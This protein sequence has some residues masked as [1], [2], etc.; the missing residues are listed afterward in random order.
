MSETTGHHDECLRKPV[1]IPREL[2]SDLV[3]AREEYERCPTMY[4]DKAVVDAIRA[5]R[6]I[7]ERQ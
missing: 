3:A 7:A 2:I 4:S 5:I 1:L 6:S